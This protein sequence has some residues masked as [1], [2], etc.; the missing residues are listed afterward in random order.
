MA[1][2]CQLERKKEG[3]KYGILKLIGMEWNSKYMLL[4]FYFFL[5]YSHG[6][7]ILIA[8]LYNCKIRFDFEILI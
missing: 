6:T 7:F 4:S 3:K 1:H 5:S 8:L 2:G